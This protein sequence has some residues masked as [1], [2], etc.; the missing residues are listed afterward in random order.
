MSKK[1][2]VAALGAALALAVGGMAFAAPGNGNGNG[3]PPWAGPPHQEREPIQTP[4]SLREAAPDGFRIG[5]AVANGPLRNEQQY[6]EVLAREFNSVT[7]E[8]AMK[9]DALQP[10]RWTFNFTD[11]DYLVE[12]AEAN[13]MDVYGHTLLWHS[14]APRWATQIQDPE[15]LR[16]AAKEHVQTVAAHFAGRVDRWDVVNEALADSGGGMRNSFLLQRLGPDFV[17]DAFRWAHEAD[18]DAELYLNDYNVSWVH[19]ANDEKGEAY[20]QLVKGLVE[21]GVPIHGVGFQ[22]HYHVTSYMSSMDEPIDQEHI[23]NHLRRFA[24]LGLKVAITEADVGMPLFGEEPT[25][26]QLH[27]QGHQFGVMLN[28]CLRTM[29]CDTFTVWGFTDRHNWIPG[30]RSGW[31]AATPMTRDYEKKP[32]YHELMATFD[33][34]RLYSADSWT[35]P[36]RR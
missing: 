23:T 9:W 5:T 30:H 24:D 4:S 27:A 17:A 18:P 35:P 19:P 10:Q 33:L 14:Q 1:T 2:T 26:V 34:V 3:P 28:A 29:A 25:S 22:G 12:F 20:Y 32:G 13:E 11:A 8:N 36:G 7:S 6:R 16:A 21:D 31:G 15:E